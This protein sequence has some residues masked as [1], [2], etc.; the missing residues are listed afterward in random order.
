MSL[1]KPTEE[2]ARIIGHGG[3]AFVA[4]CPGAGKTR[5]LVERAR[6]L[7]KDKASG[8]GIAF[9]SFTNAAVSELEQRLRQEGLLPSPVFPHFIGTFDGFLWQ[10]LVA[11]FGVPGCE[12]PPRLIPDK[13]DRTIQLGS[14][15]KLRLK[16]FDRATGE[17]VPALAKECGF[18]PDKKVSR[19]KAYVSMAASLRE[20]FLKRGELDFTD[21][22]ALAVGRLQE[23]TLSTRLARALAGRFSEVIVDEAQ[24]CNP[25]D[26]QIIQWLRDAGIATKVICDPHQSIYEF[27]GGVTEELFAFGQGFNA[28]DQLA[29]SG[30][31]R[32]SNFICKAIAAFRSSGARSDPD[33]ALGENSAVTTPVYILTYSGSSVPSS[34]G[35]KFR[36]L[37]EAEGIDLALCPVLAATRLS[38]A[39]AV[40]QPSEAN[41]QDLTLRLASAVTDFHFAFEMGNRKAALEKIHHVVLEI[42]GRMGAKTYRQYLVAE[43]IEPNVWRPKILKLVRELRYDPATYPDSDAWHTKAKTLLA[44]HLP[45]HGQSIS[46]RLRRNEGLSRVLGVAPSF[47]PP[48]RTIHAV[49]GMEFPAVCVVLTTRTTRNIL[50]YLATG[51]PADCAEDARKIYVAA[52]RAQRLLAIATPKSQAERLKTLLVAKR[53]A[54]S[55]VS[56]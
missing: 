19:T 18:D 6:V 16:C 40:G 39:R 30:N 5:V 4:A 51:S 15:P 11:P 25:A 24:D 21:A 20:R 41:A 29:M 32:S 55:V 8:R 13:D 33:R 17:V 9:L 47:S 34:V 22:R 46:Q 38:G 52:S 1:F 31:F 28:A 37:V 23:K 56:L 49:K 48:V 7:L 3:S 44:S 43:G 54:M 42:E 10:F 35:A 14:A 45:P 50:D 36:E 27:R 26:L 12:S 53:V 2:Q